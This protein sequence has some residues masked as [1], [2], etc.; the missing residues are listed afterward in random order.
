MIKFQEN[1]RREGWKYEVTDRPY[2]IRPFWLSPE[3]QKGYWINERWIRWKVMTTFTTL[4]P[5]TYG[6]LTDD[7]DESKKGK[8]KKSYPIIYRFSWTAKKHKSKNKSVNDD[9]Y[10]SHIKS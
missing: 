8:D 1:G 2:F 10:S 3:V 7:S 9:D 4:R 6:Y 5:K